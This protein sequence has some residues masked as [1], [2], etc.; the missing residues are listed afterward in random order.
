MGFKCVSKSSRGVFVYVSQ[1]SIER[2]NDN[3]VT[4]FGSTVEPEQIPV[5]QRHH[6]SRLQVRTSYWISRHLD[7]LHGETKV[8]PSFVFFL[9][10]LC[11]CILYY[12]EQ[13]VSRYRVGYTLLFA[14]SSCDISFCSLC[15]VCVCVC[16]CVWV[17]VCVCVC[18]PADLACKFRHHHGHTLAVRGS[19]NH[20]SYS[21][22]YTV[23]YFLKRLIII[24]LSHM[25]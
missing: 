1:I 3:F 19:G 6:H 16:V 8:G 18:V 4:P 20:S 11:I 24:C 12:I 9:L 5:H 17:C 13:F 23:V 21:F 14:F 15:R 25:L 10:I 7:R 22:R 2:V